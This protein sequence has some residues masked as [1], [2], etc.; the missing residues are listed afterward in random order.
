MLSRRVAFVLFAA[1]P[2]FFASN[3][4]VARWN[5]GAIPSEALA[6]WR[7]TMTLAMLLPFAGERLWRGRGEIRAHWRL[8]LFLGFLGMVVCGAPVYLAGITTTAMNIGLIYAAS[9]VLIVLLGWLR[10]GDPV[11]PRQATGIAVCLAGTLWIV[12]RGDPANVLRL[13]FVPGDLLI[14]MA[15]V[16][17]SLYSVLLRHS[18]TK[19]DPTTR[20]AAICAGGVLANIPFYLFEAFF[21]APTPVDLKT[22]AT[23]L[24]VALFPGVGSYLS[25][26]MIVAALGAATSSLVMYLVPLYGAGLAWAVLGERLAD[27]HLVGLALLLPGLWLGTRR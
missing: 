21:V 3:M 25:Y 20:L 15:M 11:S 27:F 8:Y 13:D 1:T 17:W 5:A 2:L 10:Y 7:W 12:L 18:P 23:V 16:A 26:S 24:F 4:L 22:V 6:F 14:V 9:P 19:L